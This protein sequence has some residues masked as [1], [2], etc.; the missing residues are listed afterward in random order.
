MLK[1]LAAAALGLALVSGPA[2][3]QDARGAALVTA[4]LDALVSEFGMTVTDRA[5]GRLQQNGS[6]VAQ[7]QSPG[8]AVYFIGACDENCGDVDLI[9]RDSSGRQIGE[10]MEL[11]DTPIVQFETTAGVYSVEVRMADCT[12]QCHWGVGV[13]R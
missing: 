10:D 11:D 4:Q 1:S 3:A 8:G 6:H 9:V 12:G 5:T 13:F 7:L 2:V